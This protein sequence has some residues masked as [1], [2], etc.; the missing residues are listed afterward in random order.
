MGDRRVIALVVAGVFAVAAFAVWQ[1]ALRTKREVIV[2]TPG[3][4]PIGP[5]ATLPLVRGKDV[6]VDRVSLDP[7]VTTA[8]VGVVATNGQLRP[9]LRI[10]VRDAAGRRVASGTGPRGEGVAGVV[11]VALHGR[12]P[13]GLGSVCVSGPN[14]RE[15]ELAGSSA[16][17]SKSRSTTRVAGQALDADLTLS[18]LG[19]REALGG[20][21]GTVLDH[22]ATFKPVPAWLIALLA[23][24]AVL[25]VP[26]GLVAALRGALDSR[27]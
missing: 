27:G 20:R 26:V 5:A 15:L 4:G 17:R 3:A 11:N 25:G 7:A 19:R 9:A 18:L 13:S 22:A 24:A 6:C 14:A 8:R 12:V 21:L 2:S 23:L 16:L 10:A 1:P